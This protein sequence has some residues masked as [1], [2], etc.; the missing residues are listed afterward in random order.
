MFK[1]IF[2]KSCFSSF[3]DSHY[4]KIATFDTNCLA[5]TNQVPL[6]LTEYL[7]FSPSCSA[8][9]RDFNSSYTCILRVS[10]LS[11]CGL[12]QWWPGP[13]NLEPYWTLEIS[14]SYFFFVIE[15]KLFEQKLNTAFLFILTDHLPPPPYSAVLAVPTLQYPPSFTPLSACISGCHYIKLCI[16]H[17]SPLEG[18]IG[19]TRCGH[20][21]DWAQQPW[22]FWPLTAVGEI[23]GLNSV[24]LRWITHLESLILMPV[25]LFSVSHSYLL[26]KWVT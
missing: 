14:G 15:K 13:L 2:Q 24:E 11:K 4:Y 6:W 25:Q 20:I 1:I 7:R 19:V 12:R 26:F 10:Y 16:S 17:H 23:W 18:S 8:C 9:T 21:W 3:S 5:K 22:D